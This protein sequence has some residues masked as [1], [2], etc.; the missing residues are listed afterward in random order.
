M[1]K[2]A[3]LQFSAMNSFPALLPGET[4]IGYATRLALVNQMSLKKISLDAFGLY[5][6]LEPP[7]VVPSNLEYFYH[8]ADGAL[9]ESD[10]LLNKH[11]IYPV[12]APFLAA[13][14]RLQLASQIKRARS[15]GRSTQIRASAWEGNSP[16]RMAWCI[17]CVKE[18]CERYG[19]AYWHR[20]H[21]LTFCT[22]CPAHGSPLVVSC[23]LCT[24]PLSQRATP[25][26][27]TEQCQCGRKLRSLADGPHDPKNSSLLSRGHGLIRSFFSNPLPLD[28]E[29]YITA[30]LQE[31]A[32]ELG[33][34][35][36][37]QI[38]HAV[39][40][41]L[42]QAVDGDDVMRERWPHSNETQAIRA[43][44]RSLAHGRQSTK[45]AINVIL[46]G[47]LF[48]TETDFRVALERNRQAGNASRDLSS[49][50]DRKP[51]RR[52]SN[53]AQLYLR[54]RQQKDQYVSDAIR[55][56]HAAVLA[57]GELPVRFSKA[58]FLGDVEGGR[59]IVRKLEL[60]PLCSAAIA[61]LSETH[62]QYLRRRAK[63]LLKQARTNLNVAE[64][65]KAVHNS[66]LFS[67]R[68]I[69]EIYDELCEEDAGSRN[70]YGVTP[71]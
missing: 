3:T 26:L 10:Y 37:G 45:L 30:T 12:V 64:L 50:A 1:P 18:D 27:P 47:T 51:G 6:C 5:G 65:S 7:W 49:R 28:R 48:S 24:F 40:R 41:E 25:M 8:F 71:N 17:D 66:S 63:W 13:P 34:I 32:C 4:M 31:R 70:S 67:P 39:I 57:A 38:K 9:P 54:Q 43:L 14:M 35:K 60:Y 53:H 22:Y 58:F 23:G 44:T 62:S 11:T 19:F 2:H 52:G 68:E 61:E 20:E 55:R 46:I 59:S 42:I 56:R 29:D 21:Q 16:A 15:R 69:Q 33:V 36:N